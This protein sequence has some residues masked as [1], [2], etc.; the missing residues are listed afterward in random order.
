MGSSTGDAHLMKYLAETSLTE[1]KHNVA[2]MSYFLL[3][4]LHKCLDILITTDRIPEAAFF[5]R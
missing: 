5:A 2:F 1:G 4:D 3:A